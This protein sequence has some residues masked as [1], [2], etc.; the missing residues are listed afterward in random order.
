MKERV[1]VVIS[2]GEDFIDWALTTIPFGV[3]FMCV[4]WLLIGLVVGIQVAR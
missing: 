1:G 3:I 2:L 4:T